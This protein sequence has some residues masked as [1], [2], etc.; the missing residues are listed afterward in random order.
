MHQKVSAALPP[1]KRIV[2]EGLLIALSAV[3]MAVKNDI[4][5]GALRDNL[6]YDPA[7]YAAAARKE[8]TLVAHQNEEYGLRVGHLRKTLTKARWSAD[9]TADQRHDIS[10]LAL[11]R[12]VHKKLALALMHVAEDDEQVARIVERAQ[13]VASDEISA[14][15]SAR[16][17]RLAIDS[18]DPDYERERAERT[19]MFVQIDLAVLALNHGVAT[20]AAESDY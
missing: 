7:V 6:D 1:I 19:E 20:G 12:R 9:I 3:G 18:R 14:A 10:Q 15:L 11:R 4:I 2:E 17:I 13:H 8:L 16:L 5:V